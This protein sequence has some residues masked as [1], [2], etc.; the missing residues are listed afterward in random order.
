M[1][2]CSNDAISVK[3]RQ[4]NSTQFPS[5]YRLDGSDGSQLDMFWGAKLK[6]GIEQDIDSETRL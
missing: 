3:S 1:L 6:V 4:C 2:K 5:F